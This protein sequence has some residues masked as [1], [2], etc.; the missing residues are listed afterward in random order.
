MLLSLAISMWREL[1]GV[2]SSYMHNVLYLPMQFASLDVDENVTNS[3]RTL[4]LRLCVA[5]GYVEASG[6]A[7][8]AQAV[9][10]NK[11]WIEVLYI[12]LARREYR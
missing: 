2:L 5:S 6:D 9:S 3:F 4:S 7:K 12:L 8:M 1:F 10:S 11:F